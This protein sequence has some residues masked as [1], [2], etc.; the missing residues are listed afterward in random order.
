MSLLILISLVSLCCFSSY[1]SYIIKFQ[2]V[3]DFVRSF[4][5]IECRYVATTTAKLNW[6]Q[7]LLNELGIIG[8]T[9]FKIY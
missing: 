3:K 5:E 9:L 2:N 6:L 7:H 1:Q 4:I 8:F